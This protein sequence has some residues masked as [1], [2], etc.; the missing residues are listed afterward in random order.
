MTTLFFED[1][2][3]SKYKDIGAAGEILKA[4]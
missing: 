4:R 1:F 3:T 2:A